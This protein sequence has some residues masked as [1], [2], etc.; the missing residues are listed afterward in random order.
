MSTTTTATETALALDAT[1]PGR[2][3]VRAGDVDIATY[4]HDGDFPANESRKPYLHPLRT[5]DG[6]VVTAYRP[7]DHRWHKGLQMTAS[8]VSGQNFWGGGTYV[9]GEGYVPKDNVGQMRHDGF[10]TARSSGGTVEL[11]ERLTWISSG[12]QEWAREVRSHRFGSVDPARGTWT[13]DFDTEITCTRG[14]PLELGSPTTHGRP[15]A[16][17]TGYF[18]RGPRGWTGGTITTP[19]REGEDAMGTLS[20]WL[21]YSSPHDEVDGGGTLLV[22]AGSASTTSNPEVPLTWFVRHAPFPAI[23]PSFAFHD[24]VVL[25][26]GESLRLRHRVVV[27]D[28]IWGREEIE[29][30]AAANALDATP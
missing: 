21:A 28:R 19:D 11:V 18:W 12:G 16:G 9:H 20:A 24:E 14:E 23:A 5:L 15:S 26:D 2:T 6:A 1:T 25:A 22:L 10:D 30:V 29:E 8:H 7:H 13:L 27:G 3:V 17:Y 4:V